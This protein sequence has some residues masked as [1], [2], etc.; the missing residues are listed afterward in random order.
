MIRREPLPSSGAKSRVGES[1]SRQ[2]WEISRS[3]GNFVVVFKG[4][5]TS[6]L[7]DPKEKKIQKK[8]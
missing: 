1:C 4:I 7:F 3:C 5:M 6:K 2:R 8:Y